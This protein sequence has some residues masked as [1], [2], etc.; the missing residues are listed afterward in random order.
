[1][2]DKRLTREEAKQAYNYEAGDR[3]RFRS[4]YAAGIT[5]GEYYR[6]TGVD[7]QAGTVA[8]ASRDG[9]AITWTPAK[10]GSPTVEA[11]TVAEREV[12]AGDR[13][14]WTR[15]DTTAGR[16]N[17]HTADVERIGA[18]G[19]ITIRDHRSAQTIDPAKDGDGHFRH[20]YV[21]TVHAAQGQTAD[22]VMVNAES[23]R[24]NLLNERSFYV[25]IS[26]ARE[27]IR[28]YTDNVENLTRGIEE[29]T[30]EK[31]AALDQR[32]VLKAAGVETMRADRGSEREPSTRDD[33][34]QGR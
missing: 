33:R 8:L 34:S 10:W 22:R 25:A 29:R 14:A 2:E 19:R 6:V 30:G 16:V 20:A 27:E 4:D 24:T 13:I 26:R 3:V 1:M 15:N 17:G 18:D 28:V 12:M 9:Q 32:S 21:L 11:Y 23:F 7:A 31:T 5:K